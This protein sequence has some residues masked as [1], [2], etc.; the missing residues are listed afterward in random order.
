MHGRPI[1]LNDRGIRAG[2]GGIVDRLRAGRETIFQNEIAIRIAELAVRFAVSA[3]LSGGKIFGDYSPFGAG[4]VG[5]AG[6]GT[7]G[8]VSAIGAFWGYL[9]SRDILHSIKYIG[10]I[11]LIV[12]AAF[13]FKNTN[14]YGCKCFH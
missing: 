6:A 14:A 1:N 4:W 8:I 2:V 3:I 5:A 9:L 12:T 11:L 13:V 10:I 7:P